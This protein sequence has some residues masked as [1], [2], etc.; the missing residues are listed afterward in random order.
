MTSRVFIPLLTIVVFG[1]GYG[2]RI[3]TEHLRCPVP[4]P[5][6]LLTELSTSAPTAKVSSKTTVPERPANAAKLA[7]EIERLRPSIEEFR[8]RIE[9]MDGEM[10]QQLIALLKPEQLP[11]WEKLL[12]RRVEYTQKEEAGIVG[13]GPLTSEQIAS[14]QQRPLYKLLAVVVVPQRLE[15]LTND[16]KLDQEQK[17]KA[18]GILLQRRDKFLALVD[19]SPPPS[20]TL[21]RLAPLAQR[22]GEPKKPGE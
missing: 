17:E 21:S 11:K 22:L 18:R 2:A 15:W 6:A 9:E 14:L 13:D 5:P 8:K 4:P 20:L 7:A 1:A 16:L 3:W 10:D 19:S 12:K